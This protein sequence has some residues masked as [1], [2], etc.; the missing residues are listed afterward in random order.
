MSATIKRDEWGWI[1]AAARARGQIPDDLACV[2]LDIM[3]KS[4]KREPSG[5]DDFGDTKVTFAKMTKGPR[6]GRKFSEQRVAVASKADAEAM[7]MAFEAQSGEC[8]RCPGNGK[9]VASSGVDGTTYRA[10]ARCGGT[11]KAP[12]S[13]GGAR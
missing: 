3:S 12:T 13:E 8:S 7:A 9:T 5:V 1:A 11:G 10:C 2:G 6:G 4:G